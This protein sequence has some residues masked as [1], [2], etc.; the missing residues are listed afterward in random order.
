MRVEFV[1]NHMKRLN[2]SVPVGILAIILIILTIL[3]RFQLHR[4]YIDNS[5][6]TD[7]VTLYKYVYLLL[8]FIENNS[9]VLIG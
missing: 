6:I 9:K 4:A 3:S 1:S 8:L 2:S 5:C 7:V